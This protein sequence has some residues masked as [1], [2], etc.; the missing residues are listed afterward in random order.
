LAAANSAGITAFCLGYPVRKS[1]WMRFWFVFPLFMA[2]AA[3][4]DA[5]TWCKGMEEFL[6]E[7]LFFKSQTVDG[8]EIF[9][10]FGRSN[11]ALLTI[12]AI[13]T[14]GQASK[15]FASTSP[16]N[17]YVELDSEWVVYAGADYFP[18]NKKWR[19]ECGAYRLAFNSVRSEGSVSIVV[20]VCGPTFREM[21]ASIEISPQRYPIPCIAH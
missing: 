18:Y 5:P 20:S 15:Y 8:A 10:H 11:K 7:R 9:K 3:Q 6:H 14:S 2:G 13:R 16:D 19:T 4:A 17:H 12:K 1:W 21:E